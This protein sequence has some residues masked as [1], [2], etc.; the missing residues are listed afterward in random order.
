[1]YLTANQGILLLDLDAGAGGYTS[2]GISFA[3]GA[4]TFN[5]NYAAVISE[6][7]NIDAFDV[8]GQIIATAATPAFSGTVGINNGGTT[9]P[10]VVVTGSYTL[11]GSGRDPGSLVL[12]STTLNEVFYVADANTVLCIETDASRQTS[13]LL[14]LQNPQLP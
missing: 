14:Q 5:T 1:M 11:N 6:P 3:Q 9:T 13:G 10:G 2:T 7:A 4:T 12:G 8:V